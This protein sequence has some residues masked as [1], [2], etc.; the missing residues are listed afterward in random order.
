MSKLFQEAKLMSGML[1][2]IKC[3][4]AKISPLDTHKGFLCYKTSKYA[5]HYFETPTGIKFLL[6]TDVNAQNIRDLLQQL[7]TQVKSENLGNL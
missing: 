1:Y 6:N 4:V 7:Y 2:S 5:L 3:L